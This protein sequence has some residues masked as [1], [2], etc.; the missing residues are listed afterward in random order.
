[1][2]DALVVT[3]LFLAAV[4]LLAGVAKL[5]DRK[6]TRQALTDFDVPSRPVGPLVFLLPAAELATAT[7]LLFEPGRF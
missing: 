1:M 5:A 6:G 3:R 7:A 2:D 4:F